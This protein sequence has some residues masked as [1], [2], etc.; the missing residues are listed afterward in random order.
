MTI[1]QKIIDTFYDMLIVL[2]KFIPISILTAVVKTLINIKN[3]AQ[4]NFK[5]IVYEF[6]ISVSLSILLGWLCFKYINED[7]AIMVT[8][9]TSWAGSKTSE[10]IDVLVKKYITNKVSNISKDDSFNN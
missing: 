9:V 10:T 6:I 3:E 1:I 4:R 5:N 2:I 7:T 8:A